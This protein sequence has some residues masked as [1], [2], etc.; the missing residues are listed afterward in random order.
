MFSLRQLSTRYTQLS[1]VE[2]E[3]LEL[4]TVDWS[5]LADL[6]LGDVV[7]WVPTGDDQYLAVAHARPAGL[8]TM[9]SRNVIGDY[10]RNDWRPIVDEAMRTRRPAVSPSLTWYEEAPMQ[11][12]AF[13]VSMR[14]PE[15]GERV[16]PIAVITL[17]TSATD[18]HSVSKTSAAYR[19]SGDDMFAMIQHGNFPSA[20]GTAERPRGAPRAADGLMRV[21]P[22][23]EITFA[24]PN[25]LTSFAKI[26]YRD[27]LEGENLV[28][29]VAKITKGQ[30]DTNESL[31][32]VSK[33]Q[34]AKRTDIEAR[35]RI[36]AIRSIPVVIENQ[37]IGGIILT[38]DV[39]DLRQQ[40]QELITKDATIREIHHRVKNNLQTVASLLRVQ[41]RRAKSEETK[42]VLGQAMRRVAAIAV[43]HD[44]LAS[45]VSQIVDFDEVFDRVL[46]LAAEVASLH[47]TT[48]QLVR[49]GKFGEIP[50]EYATPLALALTEVVTNAVEHGLADRDGTVWI[51]AARDEHV[52]RVAV[53]DDGRGLTGGSVGAGLGTQI[54][55]TLIEGELSGNILWGDRA[56]GGTRVDVHV[57][58]RWI[59]NEE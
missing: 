24:S 53:E 22:D 52:L 31:P 42:Q 21:D 15:S 35:G 16:G 41:A 38:R 7:L 2:I 34:V 27:E 10:L 40:T 57:P 54:V 11:M 39:T 28:E 47:G 48:V 14:D 13:S 56:G 37:R 55:K 59:I 36:V 44:T 29:V 9:F 5:L 19:E 33:A 8:I 50:S 45:G 17:H 3:W 18:T 23:G 46:G 49:D 43:V 20:G 4:L 25:T 51:H 12:T 6:A 30:L 32:L 58:L 1:E 26:G